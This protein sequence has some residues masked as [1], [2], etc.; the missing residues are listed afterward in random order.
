MRYGTPLF[1]DKS[2]EM[3]DVIFS[4][5]RNGKDKYT[6]RWIINKKNGLMQLFY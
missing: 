6:Y 4:Q 2:Q 1:I 3:R 5:G